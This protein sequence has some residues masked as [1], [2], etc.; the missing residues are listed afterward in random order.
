MRE[1]VLRREIIDTARAM[2]A[3]GINQGTSGNVSVRIEGG[4]LITLSGIDY[5]RCAPADIIRV[6]IAGNLAGVLTRASEV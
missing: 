1:H 3:Q 2:N 5:E 4:F 6:T